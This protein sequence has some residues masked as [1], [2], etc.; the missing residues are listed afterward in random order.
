MGC[1]HSSLHQIE[2][3]F[4][5]NDILYLTQSWNIVKT[6]DLQKFGQDVLI[7]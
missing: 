1:F 3:I 7:E 6:H 4:N 2:Y 5:A